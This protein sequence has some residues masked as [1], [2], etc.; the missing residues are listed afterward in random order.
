MAVNSRH[1]GLTGLFLLGLLFLGTAGGIPSAHADR[2]SVGVGFGFGDGYC[3][4]GYYRPWPRR[5]YCDPYWGP[6]VYVYRG[7]VVYDYYEVRP[8][9]PY[10]NYD[11]P[12][13]DD[14]PREKPEDIEDHGGFITGKAW[15]ALADGRF[16]EAAD[17]FTDKIDDHPS[18]GLPRIGYAITAARYGDLSTGVRAMREALHY[19]PDAIHFVPRN[20]LIDAKIDN[21]L[22]RYQSWYERAENQANPAFMIA[23]LELIRGRTSKAVAMLDKALQAGDDS[24]A[25]QNLRDLLDR[26]PKKKKKATVQSQPQPAPPSYPK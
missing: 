3:G 17:R 26:P 1:R 9:A 13:P 15:A 21:V 16:H 5:Y 10:A 24:V 4:P 7:P 19:D 2:V 18:L 22:D 14:W 23:C 25:A 11:N 20:D 12:D 6:P 8:R